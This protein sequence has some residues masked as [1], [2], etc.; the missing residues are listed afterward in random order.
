[1]RETPARQGTRT[2][3]PGGIRQVSVP[4]H[5]AGGK[6]YWRKWFFV[7]LTTGPRIISTSRTLMT[8]IILL[9]RR[10]TDFRRQP[11]FTS[12]ISFVG[13]LINPDRI[14]ASSGISLSQLF[15]YFHPRDLLPE[16]SGSEQLWETLLPRSARCENRKCR[17]QWQDICCENNPEFHPYAKLPIFVLTTKTSH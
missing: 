8:G 2:S 5:R 3:L 13:V 4:L 16:T 10:R 6:L 1:M 15:I 7:R 11:I 14:P 12:S 17:Q 9:Q